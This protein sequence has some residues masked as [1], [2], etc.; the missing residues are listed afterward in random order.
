M[1][2]RTF[3]NGRVLIAMPGLADTRFEK[4]LVLLCSHT[5][6]G[7]MGLIINKTAPMMFFSDIISQL[8]IMPEDKIGTLPVPVL[9]L[10]VLLGGPVEQ[11]R[12]FVLHSREYFVPKASAAVTDALALTA[13]T[14]ILEAIAKG[15]GPE[16]VMLALGYS[17]WVAGQLEDELQRNSWLYCDADEEM[18]FG[19]NQDDKYVHALAKIGVDPA[20][21]S[22]EAGHG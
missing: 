9:N 12:G 8:K 4:S 19:T 1:S 16:K 21:L 20:M 2:G 13:T 18:L 14:D 7:A 22:A 3:L 10:P 6:N 11:H 15:E 17:G 5:E